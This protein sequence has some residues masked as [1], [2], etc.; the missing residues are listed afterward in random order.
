MISQI[1][2]LCCVFTFACV[3]FSGQAHEHPPGFAVASASTYATKAGMAILKQGGNAFDAAIAV[4]SVLAVTEPY[5]S[6]LGGG[7]FWLLYDAQKQKNILVD[8]RES[9]PGAA[10]KS[11][12]LDSQGKVISELSLFG[13]LASA[14]PGEPAAIAHI[15]KKYGKLPLYKTLAPAIQ[16]AKSGFEVDEHYRSMIL[17]KRVMQHIKGYPSTAKIF[18]V[19]DKIPKVGDLIVQKDLAYTLEQLAKFGRNGFYQGKVAEKLVSEVRKSGGIWSLGDLKNYQVIERAPLE[20]E[21]RGTKVITTP[22]PSAGGIALLTMLNVLGNYDLQ[23]M[24]QAERTHLIVESMRLAYWDRSEFL[25]DPQFVKIPLRR[26]LSIAHAKRLR[27]HIKQDKATLSAELAQKENS[28]E[29]TSENTTHFSIID[30]QG[31]RVAATLSINFLFGSSFVAEGTGV[32]LNNEMDDFTVKPGEKNV[33]GL[34]GG[35]ANQIAANKRPLSS[36]APTF[37]INKERIAVLG[38]PGG[39]RIPTMLL[40]STLAFVDEKGPLS[41][42][43]LPR[44]H[45]QYLPDVLQYESDAFN[46]RIRAKLTKMGYRLQKIR[47]DYGGPRLYYGDMQGLEWNR[48]NDTLLAASDPRN[49]GL[50]EVHYL[51]K[52]NNS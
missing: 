34:V 32:L 28:F 23:D 14:I 6:G 18:L 37:L 40:L 51:L 52:T 9:A 43:S 24:K 38:T 41:F 5:H 22:P 11:M 4:T 3:S 26:L 35:E 7:G 8:G 47:S 16:L 2:R 44:F 1:K 27:T 49:I 12:Y 50:A 17:N 29:D 45:H 10:S 21:Y 13:P 30:Q 42:V 25:G 33:F 46:K 39:S 31:N 20:G 19:K 48:Q 36:M 15:A